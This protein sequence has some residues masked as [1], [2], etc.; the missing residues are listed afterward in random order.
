MSKHVHAQDSNETI[1]LRKIR[2]PIDRKC[3]KVVG[4]KVEVCSKAYCELEG[5]FCTVYAFP[6]VKWHLG[7]CPMADEFLQ[8]KETQIGKGKVRV[9]QQKQKK[10][11]RRR[12]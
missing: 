6:D 1:E 9:G 11:A 3:Y 4:D 10:K 5:Q 12:A 7:N 8:I 2:K